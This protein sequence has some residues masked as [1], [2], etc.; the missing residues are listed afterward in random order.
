MELMSYREFSH[1]EML[2]EAKL[3]A[4][5]KKIQ[6]AYKKRKQALGKLYDE[7]DATLGKVN[8]DLAKMGY[9]ESDDYAPS[10]DASDSEWEAWEKLDAE[11][12]KKYGVEKIK[13]AITSENTKYVEEIWKMM[14]SGI[15]N[16][17]N[18]RM[19]KDVLTDEKNKDKVVGRMESLFL[20]L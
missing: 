1:K 11:L 2:G 17:P 18:L 13:S 4:F 16:T 14:K 9:K 15:N 12:T 20:K 7:L 5:E 6:D 10:V 19:F 8:K 3:N